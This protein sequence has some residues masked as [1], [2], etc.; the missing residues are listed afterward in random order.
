[1][2]QGL[3]TADE[4]VRHRNHADR[5]RLALWPREANHGAA[6]ADLG[7]NRIADDGALADGTL[8]SVE[9][10]VGGLG[11]LQIEVIFDVVGTNLDVADLTSRHDDPAALAVANVVAVN[12]DLM[13]VHAIQKD[14]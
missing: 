11:L 14:A 3:L 6:G 4:V 1:M 2:D 7:L 5:I 13:Q 8:A 10:N 12:V 9:P